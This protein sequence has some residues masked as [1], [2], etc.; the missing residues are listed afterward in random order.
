MKKMNTIRYMVLRA[1]KSHDTSERDN[2]DRDLPEYSQ[3]TETS[4]L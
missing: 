3:F 1:D 2:E 4:D